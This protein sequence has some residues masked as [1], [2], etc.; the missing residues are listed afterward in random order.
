MSVRPHECCDRC[1]AAAKLEAT[2]EA[3]S[4]KNSP[5]K[6]TKKR[7]MNT[8]LPHQPVSPS[9]NPNDARAN[10]LFTRLGIPILEDDEEP[11]QVDEV[12][13]AFDPYRFVVR[14]AEDS[15]D[16]RGLEE[17]KVDES[18]SDF[19][20]APTLSR[21][22]PKKRQGEH[23]AAAIEYLAQKRYEIW[24]AE[25]TH[26]PLT[27]SQLLPQNRLECIAKNRETAATANGLMKIWFLAR[28]YSEEILES[29]EKL[30][31]AFDEKKRV[32][33][34][35]K[36]H[37]AAALK[38]SRTSQEGNSTPSSHGSPFFLLPPITTPISYRPSARPWLGSAP[39]PTPDEASQIKS[40]QLSV[41]KP[42]NLQ[43]S[44]SA[45]IQL[46]PKR[47]KK[48]AENNVPMSPS[49]PSR[50]RILPTSR[51]LHCIMCA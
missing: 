50:S 16:E 7:R 8:A 43:P 20:Y 48:G 10:A 18:D 33:A 42:S 15:D 39:P 23:L 49:T 38:M 51:M 2:Q 45:S 5:E 9:P 24:L 31:K 34:V 47:A 46:T 22:R 41:L 30:D 32:D 13:D 1:E 40:H 26:F 25:Y 14:E 12:I 4:P 36:K 27:P 29:L 19:E 11:D 17:E 6:A 44:T 37:V 3:I 21:R 35:E 28:P